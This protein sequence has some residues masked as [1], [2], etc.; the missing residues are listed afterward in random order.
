MLNL[1]GTSRSK[2]SAEAQDKASKNRRFPAFAQRILMLD[3]FNDVEEK[4]K[5][6][7][8]HAKKVSQGSQ[9]DRHH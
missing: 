3:A 5:R 8:P 7:N 1:S 6:D 9:V 2:V 4:M